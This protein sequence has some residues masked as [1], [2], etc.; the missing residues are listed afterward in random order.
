M[1]ELRLSNK[2]RKVQ[3]IL[4]LENC[5]EPLNW[6]LIKSS[7]QK[8][9]KASVPTYRVDLVWAAM[10]EQNLISRG[11]TENPAS[12]WDSAQQAEA[13][14]LKE[15]RLKK[16]LSFKRMV[17]VTNLPLLFTAMGPGKEAWTHLSPFPE[18]PYTLHCKMLCNEM[19]FIPPGVRL[20]GKMK[21]SNKLNEFAS[22]NFSMLILS[23][24]AL[25]E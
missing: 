5:Y 2:M 17:A 3:I 20:S 6:H 19:F 10:G 8:F 23:M 14:H 18:V 12:I 13:R 25:V 22:W 11:F 1:A 16:K 7:L 4:N 21:C 24:L 15:R 9:I